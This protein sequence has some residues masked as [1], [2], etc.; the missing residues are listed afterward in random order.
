MKLKVELADVARRVAVFSESRI[1]ELEQ[2][3]QKL[4]DERV[5]L[6]I[7]LEEAA[8]EPSILS[9][10]LILFQTIFVRFIFS[11][12]WTYLE[13]YFWFQVGNK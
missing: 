11:L 4:A 10:V 5:L 13:R 9:S 8:R 3:L 2:I 6:E 12:Q 1:V 7:K